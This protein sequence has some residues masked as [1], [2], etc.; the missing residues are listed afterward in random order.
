MIQIEGE[1]LNAKNLAGK[2]KEKLGDR[3]KKNSRWPG[4]WNPIYQQRTLNRHGL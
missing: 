3:I 4:C 2:R 1:I